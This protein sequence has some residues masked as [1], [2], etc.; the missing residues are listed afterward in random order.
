MV[1][2]RVKEQCPLS[3]DFYVV[4]SLT[5]FSIQNMNQKFTT[6]IT[7]LQCMCMTYVGSLPVSKCSAGRDCQTERERERERERESQSIYRQGWL[8]S[9]L[10]SSRNGT[11]QLTVDSFK[12]LRLIEVGYMYTKKGALIVIN[13]CILV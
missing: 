5:F 7:L 2:E 4:E 6:D 3:M 9:R 13:F 1:R 12:G 8:N 10:Y 11:R